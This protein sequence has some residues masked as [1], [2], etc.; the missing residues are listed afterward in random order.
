MWN[1]RNQILHGAS[2]EENVHIIRSQLQEEMRAHYEAYNANDTYVLPR[3][4]YLF[5]T[6]TLAQ[7]M[8]FSHDHITCWLRS[9]QEARAILSF[10]QAHQQETSSR[11]FN[12]FAHQPL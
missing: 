10:Q 2:M 8:Q 3:H 4:S 9:V 1:N 11:V 12:L 5:T 7:R 6:R